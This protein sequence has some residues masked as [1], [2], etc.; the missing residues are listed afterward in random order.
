MAVNRSSGNLYSIR[1]IRKIK[2][3][4]SGRVMERKVWIQ[5]N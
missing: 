4:V 2:A 3:L 5:Y 1:D